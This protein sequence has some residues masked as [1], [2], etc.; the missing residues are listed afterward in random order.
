MDEVCVVMVFFMSMVMFEDLLVNGI[1]LD[2]MVDWFFSGVVCCL[3]EV[4]IWFVI[5]GWILFNMVIMWI[6]V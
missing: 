4:E 3:C 2:G 1:V 6:C 5:E